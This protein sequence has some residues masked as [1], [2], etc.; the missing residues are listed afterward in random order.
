MVNLPSIEFC[1]G[2][3]AQISKSNEYSMDSRFGFKVGIA[4]GAQMDYLVTFF[5]GFLVMLLEMCAFRVLTVNFGSSVYV[6][7]TL[8]T[9]IM[10]A[11]SAGYYCG[12]WL[13]SRRRGVKGL[14]GILAACGLYLAVFDLIFADSILKWVSTVSSFF[15]LGSTLGDICPPALA[16]LILYGTPMFLLSQISPWMI[17]NLDQ[18][19]EAGHRS[20]VILSLSTVGSI[21]GTLLTSY[22]AL[23][24]L[25]VKSTLRLGVLICS[26]LVPFL[27]LSFQDKKWQLRK[28]WVTVSLLGFLA[29]TSFMSWGGENTRDVVF[30]GETRYGTAKIL[31]A[32]S[33]EGDEFLRYMPSRHYIHS[34]FF[35]ND[36]LRGQFA[37]T[38]FTPVLAR[39]P[40]SYLV[41]G[42]AVG[43]VVRQIQVVDPQATI[44]A[45][46]IDDQV[47][48]LGK[49]YFGVVPTS[50]VELV[51]ADAKMFLLSNRKKFDHIIMDIYSGEFVPPHCITVEFF[52]LLGESLSAGGT[53]YVN[54]NSFD[55]PYGSPEK[56][57]VFSPLHHLE[58]TLF[59]AG[60]K[61][62]VENT[63]FHSIYAS[64]SE[65][66]EGALFQEMRK[67]YENPQLNIHL[68]AA[69]AG[70]L[71][72]MIP[73]DR[74]RAKLRAYDNDWVP[75]NLIQRKTNLAQFTSALMEQLRG[76]DLGQVESGWVH[77]P[78]GRVSLDHLF[79][80]KLKDRGGSSRPKALD[81][82][83]LDLPQ[84]CGLY[85]KS[86]ADLID[87][88][89]VLRGLA[90]RID[91]ARYFSLGCDFSAFS[92]TVST[93]GERL[94]YAY[95][96]GMYALEVDAGPRA[97]ELLSFVLNQGF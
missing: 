70:N 60:F 32:K 73:V 22:F 90:G 61:S 62:M 55:F 93:L 50:Q 67:E 16:G 97:F 64:K 36:P 94:I 51:N 79:I 78:V 27:F 20:G 38:Y 76:S 86:L 14:A 7:G 81:S 56:L 8:L 63:L 41:L 13:S 54:S 95:S 4:Y 28:G 2:Y 43:S 80:R 11:L 29:W 24:V 66:F 34:E 18:K 30:F 26:L 9:L 68:R 35:P 82:V 89:Q 23:P 33:P 96:E 92:R 45:V 37:L 21:F 42:A 1:S 44:T 15:T 52:K 25:G 85:F 53:V 49:K 39:K 77:S 74:E 87:H 91:L 3:R 10:V 12:G 48:E 59:Q 40:K 71:L 46:E 84:D 57:G 47:I 69:L 72:K 75:E 6:T 83:R 5:G 65:D 19:Y 58:A 17:Q 31:K 88:N